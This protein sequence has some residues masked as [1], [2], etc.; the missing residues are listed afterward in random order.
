MRNEE[1]AL[2]GGTHASAYVSRRTDA[3]RTC[4]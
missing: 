3:M 1:R 2:Y 4:Y